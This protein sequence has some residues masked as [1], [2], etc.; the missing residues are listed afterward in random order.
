MY[1]N[2]STNEILSKLAD[3][4]ANPYQRAKEWKME[5]GSKVVGCYIMHFPE[6]LIHAAGALP[7]VLQVIEEPIT[8]G[9]AYYPSYFCGPTRSIVDQA[10]KGDLEFL[11]AFVGGDYCIQ[12]VGGTEVLGNLLP[13][14]NNMFF[15]LPVGNQP[16]T[17]GDIVTGLQELKRDIQRFTG[18]E[19]SDESISK[20]IRIYNKNRSLIRKIYDLKSENPGLLTSSEMLS[21][22]KSSM[23]MPK[24]EHNEIL[25]TLVAKLAAE[26]NSTRHDGVRVFISGSFCGAPKSEVLSLIEESGA[27]VVGDDLFHGYR[28]TSN[29]IAEDREPIEAIADHYLEKNTS[30]PCPTRCDPKTDWPQYLVDSMR[31]HKAD[32]LV[33]LM[34]QF[35]EPHMFFYPDIKDAMQAEKIPHLLL[36]LSHELDSIETIKTRLEAFVEMAV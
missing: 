1:S 6:E 9:H 5:T 36:E 13:N 18:N 8:N 2:L 34:T 32:Q 14:A 30:V 31:K 11:D 15:R 7:V 35:C 4:A 23:V 26:K 22:I 28:Y 17:Q 10:A 19:I 21:I 27:V 12:V 33:I 20:S 16:W 29:N 25:E 3:V 24:E